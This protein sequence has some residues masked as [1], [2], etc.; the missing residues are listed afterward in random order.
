[1][2]APDV[3]PS[4]PLTQQEPNTEE[5]AVVRFLKFMAER[6]KK[7][8]DGAEQGDASALSELG[9]MYENGTG[10]PK[11]YAEA[12]RWFRKAA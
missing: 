9:H 8:R 1:V 5:P 10:V 12:V 3:R 6:A 11:D 2:Q 7:R 4:L